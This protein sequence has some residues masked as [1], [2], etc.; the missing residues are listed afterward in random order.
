MLLGID[1]SNTGICF[2][3]LEKW[4][5]QW[6]PPKLSAATLANGFLWSPF[7]LPLFKVF[8]SSRT[9]FA[10]GTLWC[11]SRWVF[12]VHRPHLPGCFLEGP[13]L[14]PCPFYRIEMDGFH[15]L[16]VG[17]IPFSK[18]QPSMFSKGPLCLGKQ[19]HGCETQNETPC[20]NLKVGFWLD[21]A[22][23]FGLGFYLE[24]I[25]FNILK[26][27]LFFLSLEIPELQ[28][29]VFPRSWALVSFGKHA[30]YL[31]PRLARRLRSSSASPACRS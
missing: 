18:K 5:F 15:W 17:F 21:L 29:P 7:V 2:G 28:K 24:G 8:G 31:E 9:V 25:S 30:V 1:H 23:V 11:T 6:T 22:L 13:C 20:P 10:F 4:Q 12:Y 19:V 27:S 3:N 26:F 14:Y 16:R